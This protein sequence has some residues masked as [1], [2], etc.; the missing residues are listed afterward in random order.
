MSSFSVAYYKL[1][2]RLFLL[3]A[4][5]VPS[6]GRSVF[7]G[8]GSRPKPH[9]EGFSHGC[10]HT[11]LCLNTHTADLC[12]LLKGP[13]SLPRTSGV[14]P[15]PQLPHGCRARWH[16]PSLAPKPGAPQE[17]EQAQGQPWESIGRAMH[18]PLSTM[19]FTHLPR[20]FKVTV[21]FW[22]V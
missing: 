5:P 21:I 16:K 10:F 6:P 18:H 15:C 9:T 17:M 3:M 14:E 11:C 13:C 7:Q 4:R 1:G 22:K 2:P 12:S 20:K 19:R 8:H